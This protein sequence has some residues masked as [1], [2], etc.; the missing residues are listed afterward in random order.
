M[1]HALRFADHG[2][3]QVGV[4]RGAQG[5]LEHRL[6]G[7]RI[8]LDFRVVA[9]QVVEDRLVA[10]DVG[11]LGVEQGG[12]LADGI[13]QALVDGYRLAWHAGCRPTADDVALAL[14]QGADHGDP[15]LFL[16]RQQTVAVLQQDQSFASHLAGGLAVQAA[17]GVGVERRVVRLAQAP[18]GIGEQA[19][20]VLRRQH[21]AAGAIDVGLVD[22]A[23]RQQL[24]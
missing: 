6:G 8:D 3:H 15:P 11:T 24:R 4:A 10:T 9:V 7:A 22:L 13:G 21:V 17:L 14:G 23:G 12:T 19:E 2:D 5:L 16:Q 20:V 18:V 1:G